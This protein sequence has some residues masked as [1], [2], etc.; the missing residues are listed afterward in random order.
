MPKLL[1]RSGALALRRMFFYKSESARSPSMSTIFWLKYKKSRRIVRFVGENIAELVREELSALGEEAAENTV[2][3]NAPRS[4]RSLREIGYD[5][6]A[7]VARQVAAWAL[8]GMVSC[9]NA[10][11]YSKVVSPCSPHSHT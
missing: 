2:I 3:T 5:Q 7:E 9:P 8:W 1:E 11:P 10:V 4:L 6:S